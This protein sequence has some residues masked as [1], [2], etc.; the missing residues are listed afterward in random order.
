MDARNV[1]PNAAHL[2]LAELE[3]AGKL[4]AVVTQN[5]DGLH[6][7]AGSNKVYELHGST[8]RNYCVNCGKRYPADFVFDSPYPVPLCPVCGGTVRC[9]VTL[10]EESLP[11][12]AVNGA[13]TAISNADA[14]IIGGTSLTVYP[15]ASFIGYFR[16]KH[17]VV[18]NKDPLSLRIDGQKY[19]EINAPIGE[20]FSALK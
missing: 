2:Y 1:K 19:L 18:I 5:I 10:Y 6:Q 3:K 17:L 9:D 12:K 14:L 20:V 11:E 8:L 15:A 4:K 7:K 13:V 16:G